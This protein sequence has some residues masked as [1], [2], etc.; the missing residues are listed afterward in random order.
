MTCTGGRLAAFAEVMTNSPSPVMSAVRGRLLGPNMSS[1]ESTIESFTE[2]ARSNGWVVSCG[3][4]QPVE[5]PAS[6]TE[7]YRRIPK[8]ILRFSRVSGGAGNKTR[9]H[10]SFASM[11]IGIRTT[12]AALE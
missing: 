1:I 2:A 7:R 9:R 6:I 11:T 8:N 4:A 12:R 5:L 10:G 3:N